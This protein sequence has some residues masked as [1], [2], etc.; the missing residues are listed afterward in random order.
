LIT[1]HLLIW[2]K[3]GDNKY[4]AEKGAQSLPIIA[5]YPAAGEGA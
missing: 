4:I 1:A 3:C 5:S 2:P